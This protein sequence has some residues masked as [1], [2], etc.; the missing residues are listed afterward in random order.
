MLPTVQ[1]AL[2]FLKP[3]AGSEVLSF[4][5]GPEQGVVPGGSISFFGEQSLSLRHGRHL[6]NYDLWN[7]WMTVPRSGVQQH[8][9]SLPVR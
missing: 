3:H 1:T 5:L 7:N 8:R 9:R 2:Q 4:G 6:N